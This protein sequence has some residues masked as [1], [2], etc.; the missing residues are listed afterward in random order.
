MIVKED[1]L[2]R[3]TGFELTLLWVCLTEEREDKTG[4]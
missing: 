1:D 4:V 3:G 2:Y